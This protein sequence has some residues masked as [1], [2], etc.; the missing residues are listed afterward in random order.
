MNPFWIPDDL[1]PS[2]EEMRAERRA[3]A[4]IDGIPPTEDVEQQILLSALVWG[5]LEN[6]A[7]V[8]PILAAAEVDPERVLREVR[9]TGIWQDP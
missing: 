6:P 9:R 5:W 8:A 4:I 7:E 3:L 2:I 1:P